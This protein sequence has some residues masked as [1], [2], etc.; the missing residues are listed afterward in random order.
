M[1]KLLDF[2]DIVRDVERRRV[3]FVGRKK[4]TLKTAKLAAV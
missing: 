2:L 4:V 3:E 1:S